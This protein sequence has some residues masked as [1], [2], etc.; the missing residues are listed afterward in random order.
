MDK[1]RDVRF[2]IMIPQEAVE[3]IDEFVTKIPNMKRN[4]F[5]SNLVLMG[6]DDVKLLDGLGILKA[7][8]IAR[9]VI[10]GVADVFGNEGIESTK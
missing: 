1:K 9:I 6:L 3:R 4:Q 10:A 5:I 2:Q 8:K 7:A